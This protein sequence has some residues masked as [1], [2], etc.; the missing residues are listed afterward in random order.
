VDSDLCKSTNTSMEGT[1]K[2]G[3]SD[4]TSRLSQPVVILAD[5]IVDEAADVDTVAEAEDIVVLAVASG[6]T[7]ADAF[8]EETQTVATDGLTAK[9]PSRQKNL[10]HRCLDADETRDTNSSVFF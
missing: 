8:S 5:R 10:D 9:A 2:T 3:A 1:Q 7:S 6:A 4:N